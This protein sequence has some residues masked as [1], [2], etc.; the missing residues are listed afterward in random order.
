[1]GSDIGS[2]AR[3]K[4]FYGWWMVGGAVVCQF[5]SMGV[6]QAV[7]GVFLTPVVT[8]LGWQVW[9]FTLGMSLAAGAGGL[10]GIVAGSVVDRRG[11]RLLIILGAVAAATC[12]LGVSLQSSLWVFLALYALSGL[13]G[14]NL[15]GPV[16][17]NPTLTKWFVRKRGWAL[18][19]GSIG[20]S[21]S[22]LIAPVAMTFVVDTWDWRVGYATM[23][24]FLLL[25]VAPV[26]LLMRRS[27]EDYGLLPDG[28]RSR[29]G[30]GTGQAPLW[31]DPG[32]FTR[33]EALGSRA[34]WLLVAGFGLNYAALSSVLIHAIPMATDSGFS[35]AVAASALAV[36][37]LGNLAS[38]LLWGF[39]LQR[40]H[41]RAL[42]ITAFTTSALGVALILAASVTGRQAALFPGFFLYGFGFGGTIPLGEFI[43]AKYFGRRH[44]G[45]IRGV[46]NPLSIGFTGVGPIL[47]GLWFDLS[48]T[49]Q[50]A[51]FTIIFAYLVGAALVGVS[52]EPSRDSGS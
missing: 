1:M 31:E 32:S 25:A 38:K 28:D 16:V 5:A 48:G 26:G 4:P 10:S 47:V 29:V 20:V 18:A 12:Y 8:E 30:G 13:I 27:P 9:Q 50:P 17:I 15:F 35:R 14:W 34:F 42:I 3:A 22:G 45:A 23:A 21:F 36:N 44:I 40:V 41:P 37:G 11:P 46:G 7:V 33:R 49:Y 2:T 19:T 51:F 6:S 52:R 24:A 43:W 39:G